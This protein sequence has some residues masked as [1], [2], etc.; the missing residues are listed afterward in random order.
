MYFFLLPNLVGKK[1]IKKK[2]FEREGK[3]AIFPFQGFK[4]TISL[5]Y[6]KQ[7]YCRKNC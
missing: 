5:N 7:I 4:S 6:W 1:T 3:I 2:N